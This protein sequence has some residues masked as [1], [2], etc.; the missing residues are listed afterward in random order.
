MPGRTL[1]AKRALAT[2]KV[3]ADWQAP[4]TRNAYEWAWLQYAA[5]PCPDNA[6]KPIAHDPAAPWPKRMARAEES[7]S[8]EIFQ[9]PAA[10]AVSPNR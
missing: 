8:R 5:Q 9:P 4:V 7:P 3:A 6:P 1:C 2:L 10:G